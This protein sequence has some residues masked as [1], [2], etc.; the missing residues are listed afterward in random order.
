VGLLSTQVAVALLYY[1]VWVWLM[2]RS[3]RMLR[4][5]SWQAFRIANLIFRLEV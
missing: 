1:A 5:R 3:G 4:S 2:L